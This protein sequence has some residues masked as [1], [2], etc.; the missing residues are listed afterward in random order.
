MNNKCYGLVRVSSEKQSTNTSLQHQRK[1]IEKYCDYHDIFL[2][3]TIKEVYSGVKN[4]RNSIQIL[5]E[6][7]EQ[8]KC[9]QI[10]VMKIDRLMRS[11]SEGVV[12][13]K[14]LLD[15]DV[16]I[17]SVKE[18]ITT[19]SVSG[20]FYVNLLLSLSELERNT[21]VERLDVGKL[22]NFKNKKRFSGRV[23]FGYRKT[24]NGLVVDDNEKKIVRYIFKKYSELNK[25]DISQ[26]MKTQRL[27]KLL[28]KNEYKYSGKDFKS[29]QVKYIL[30]NDFYSGVLYY[31]NMKTKHN[32]D[33]IISQRLF[34]LVN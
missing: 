21:I 1:L 22:N 4:D 18:E 27:L 9:N 10:I 5:R 14:F 6:L 12:F 3:D 34:N 26:T 19:E 25:L 33:K 30:R 8:G 24:N 23:C 13:I 32:Y 16:K 31:R 11:F 15:N 20:K 29:Y 17:I 28:K 7:V 2:V